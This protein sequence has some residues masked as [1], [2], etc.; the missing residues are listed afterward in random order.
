MKKHFLSNLAA[1]IVAASFS[2]ISLGVTPVEGAEGRYLLLPPGSPQ[3]YDSDTVGQLPSSWSGLP[4]VNGNAY[5]TNNVSVSAPNSFANQFTSADTTYTVQ[6]VAPTTFT[7]TNIGDWVSYDFDVNVDYIGGNDSEG[8]SFRLWNATFSQIDTGAP[9]ILRNLTQW[10]LYN[11]LVSIN[12]G[13]A[14][15][16]GWN[17]DEWH[18]L[19]FK[20]VLDGTSGPGATPYFGRT[21]WYVDDVLLNTETWTNRNFNQ[22]REID[23]VDIRSVIGTVTG[24]R[25]YVD[26]M[27]IEVIPEPSALALLAAGGWILVRRR[28]SRR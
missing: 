19:R 12:G 27:V 22:V 3:A 28:R 25:M 16:G 9:R 8:F 14:Y 1:G 13:S 5:V 21:F 18:H 26:N 15:V 4:V 10:R 20:T 7:L 23:T 11:G 17:F 6:T 2:F 24:A